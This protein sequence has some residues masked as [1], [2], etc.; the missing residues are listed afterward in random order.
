[1]SAAG[2]VVACADG[3]VRAPLPWLRRRPGFTRAA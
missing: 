3:R 2:A 1:M